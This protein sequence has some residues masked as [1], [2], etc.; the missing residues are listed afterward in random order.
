MKKCFLFFAVLL[1]SAGVAYSQN[2]S[3]L[4]SV[5]QYLLQV[6]SDW[7]IPGM[8]M[9][10]M[11]DG[12]LIYAKGFG[13]REMGGNTPVDENTLYHVGSISKSFTA[14]VMASL[15]DEG[16]V[17]WDDT[18]KNILPDFQWYDKWVEENMQIKD[19]MTHKTGL[20]GQQG[21]YIPNAG[22]DRD[23]VYHM[24][25]LLKPAHSFRAVYDY[26]NMTFLIAEKI[27]E[28]K[29]GKSWEENLKERI[30]E[31]LGMTSTCLN[32]EGYLEAG[33]KAS[34]AHE[35][36]Y[37]KDSMHVAPLYGD[38][39]ALFWQTVIGPAGSVCSNVLD[40]A[41]YAQ[42][43]L[44]MGKV[45]ER[46]VISEKNMNYL[47]KGQTIVAQSDNM[48]RLYGHCWYVEQN[49]K[50]RLYF[51]TGTT[52]GFTAICAYVPQI[53]LGLVILVNSEAPSS[54]RYAIMRRTIDLFMGDT[55]LK[56]YN[57][58]YLA[59]WWKGER[60]D[61]EKTQAA[62][63]ANEILPAMENK[64]F[65]GRYQKDELFSDVVV[66]EEDGKLYIAVG[67]QGWKREL[68][69]VSGLEYNFRSDGWGFPVTFGL[70]KKG[71]KAVS[72]SID[73]GEDEN[74]SPW[75]RK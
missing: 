64:L 58:E 23:D 48:I 14:A 28:K 30:L 31:P 35:F 56:D 50:Y 20:Q 59:D 4:N 75:T 3:I 21:T 2:D 60:A 36:Y 45:G 32:G 41:K 13:V 61:Y 1:F 8:S 68:K 39:R 26:N 51:H 63:A 18:V 29:T 54:P 67:K 6:K 71:T 65:V 12:E 70:N 25:K 9:S 49:D 72:L 66:T 37:V 38:E 10:I 17:S 43:H 19:L 42:F 34:I 53:D 22:Y 15:V 33:D 62:N 73:F 7:N 16:L 69:H 5:E 11:K 57:E 55:V 44:D 24:L 27:I 52:W 46:Q 74:F 40:M 47:H